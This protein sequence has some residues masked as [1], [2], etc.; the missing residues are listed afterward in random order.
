VENTDEGV[1]ET[2]L[3]EKWD[4]C[5]WY[6]GE[7]VEELGSSP[8]STL[9]FKALERKRG[10]LIYFTWTYPAIVPYLKG[11][12]QFLDS[13]QDNQR[14]DGWKMMAKEIGIKM[15]ASLPEQEEDSLGEAPGM[16]KAAPRFAWDMEALTALFLE[17]Q[18]PQ[19]LIRSTLCLLVFYGF[20]DASTAGHA[21][22]FQGFRRT[23]NES[24]S[25]DERIHY[26]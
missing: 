6:I 14:D 8:E 9:D 18:P 26:L 12:Q 3:Q 2:V 23:D 21:A 15:K 19:R 13:W 16:V 22:N 20:G 1:F 5:R 17:V 24:V 25:P 4:K 7:F 10:F 11:M